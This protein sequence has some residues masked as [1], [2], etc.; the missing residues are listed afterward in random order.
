MIVIDDIFQQINDM[1][2]KNETVKSFSVIPLEYDG[3]YEIYVETETKRRFRCLAT[4]TKTLSN[5]TE[6]KLPFNQVQEKQ[7]K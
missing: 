7:G 6:W 3:Y 4:R 2:P 5:M 1:L